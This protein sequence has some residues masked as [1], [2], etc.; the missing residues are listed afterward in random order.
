MFYNSRIEAWIVPK[1]ACCNR[2]ISQGEKT[3]L[4]F[5]KKQEEASQIATSESTD[6]DGDSSGGSRRGHL[7]YLFFV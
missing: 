5:K 6:I 3:D 1:F 7:F 2:D 4:V